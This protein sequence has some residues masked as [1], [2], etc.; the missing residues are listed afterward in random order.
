[1]YANMCQSVL[2]KEITTKAKLLGKAYFHRTSVMCAT[3]SLF[4]RSPVFA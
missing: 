2:E 1:M 4:K 3:E